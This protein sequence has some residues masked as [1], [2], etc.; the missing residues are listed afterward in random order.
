MQTFHQ[1][2]QQG[3][4]IF[5]FDAKKGSQVVKNTYVTFSDLF[6]GWPL[7]PSAEDIFWWFFIPFFLITLT[8]GLSGTQVG[9]PG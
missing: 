9:Q 3:I 4:L 8:L 5:A 6:F 2:L 7:L 1:F